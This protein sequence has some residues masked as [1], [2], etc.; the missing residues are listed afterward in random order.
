MKK[1]LLEI[2]Q[3]SQKN[4]CTR[5]SFLIKLQ[6]SG[7]ETLTQL[8]SREFCKISKNT[9]FTENLWTTAFETSLGV[10]YLLHATSIS[11]CVCGY[12]CVV[13]HFMETLKMTAQFLSRSELLKDI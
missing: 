9:F 7:K 10:T 6:A 13:A 5:V 2:S 1:M 8:F 12:V 4:T 11:T 3:N